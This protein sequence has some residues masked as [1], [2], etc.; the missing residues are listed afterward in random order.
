MIITMPPLTVHQQEFH[1]LD[2]KLSNLPRR[3]QC[4]LYEEEEEEGETLIHV[5]LLM[6]EEE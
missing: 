5:T 6:V 2:V 4:Q 3:Q 1:L